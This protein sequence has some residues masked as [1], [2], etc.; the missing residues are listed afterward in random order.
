MNP[1]RNLPSASIEFG[2]AEWKEEVERLEPRAPARVKAQ[3]ARRE[4]EAG[5][6]D[7]VWVAIRSQLTSHRVGPPPEGR[8]ADYLRGN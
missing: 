3:A 5:E 4:I 2:S 6:T 8:P 7:L 1:A